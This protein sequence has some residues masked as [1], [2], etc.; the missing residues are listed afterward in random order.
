MEGSGKWNDPQ[1]GCA[2]ATM[3]PTGNPTA[4]KAYF[5]TG[6]E[7]IAVQVLVIFTHEEDVGAAC[8]ANSR[9]IDFGH[10]SLPG[11]AYSRK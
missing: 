11:R 2:V 3:S 1:I 7:R 5:G 4:L 10:T 8:N 6:V 9:A